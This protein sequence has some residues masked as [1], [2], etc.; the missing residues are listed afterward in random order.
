MLGIQLAIDWL[1]ATSGILVAKSNTD[2][3]VLGTRGHAG[4]FSDAL[5]PH[6]I[7]VCIKMYIHP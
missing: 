1:Q 2:T 7:V 3:G 4:V 5:A 6:C